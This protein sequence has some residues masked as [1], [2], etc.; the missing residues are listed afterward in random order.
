MRGKFEFLFCQNFELK[1]TDSILFISDTQW[2][3]L[4]VISIVS[5]TY[6][7]RSVYVFCFNFVSFFLV[8]ITH[9]KCVLSV[10]KFESAVDLSYF[11]I[12][13]FFS[14]SGNCLD[15]HLWILLREFKPFIGP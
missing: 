3:S 11:R 1:K 2:V 14:L 10:L 4:P 15:W 12:E 7:L 9:R 6:I 13:I 8:L 5:L